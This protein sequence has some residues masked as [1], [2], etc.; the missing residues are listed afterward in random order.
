M[1]FG[2]FSPVPLRF[3]LL[4]V[5]ETGLVSALL[6]GGR[7]LTPPELD[8][9]RSTFLSKMG[10]TSTPSTPLTA[11][12]IPN[13][14]WDIYSAIRRG[15][16]N[17]VNVPKF[18]DSVR[19]YFPNLTIVDDQ[20]LLHLYFNLS[21]ET[22]VTDQR[23]RVELRVRQPDILQNSA[24]RIALYEVIDDCRDV[25]RL[26]DTK[27]IKDMKKIDWISLDAS[28]AVSRTLSLHLIVAMVDGNSS[29]HFANHS[30]SS[31]AIVIFAVSE[32][33]AKA[34]RPK[35]SAA[36]ETEAEEEVQSRRRL[37]NGQVNNATYFY[38]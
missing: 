36:Q 9:F 16:R 34:L 3:L 23:L 10:L 37:R 38:T 29:D 19:N 35:R 21:S 27:I 4:F 33:S 2:D 1:Q 18:A 30:K 28:P 17:D 13:Y 14:L 5:V 7:T 20:G 11:S 8:A 26:L 25:R 6:Q 24:G 22:S 12:P 15:G 32:D 31:A